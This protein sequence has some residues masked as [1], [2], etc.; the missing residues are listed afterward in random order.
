[1][2]PNPAELDWLL[3]AKVSVRCQECRTGSWD[4]SSADPTFDRPNPCK[5]Q[6]SKPKMRS[7]T[8]FTGGDP[9]R[10]DEI[11]LMQHG[12][13]SGQQHREY[14]TDQNFRIIPNGSTNRDSKINLW[15]QSFARVVQSDEGANEQ[16]RPSL[17][18]GLRRRRDVRRLGPVGASSPRGSTSQRVKLWAIS[19]AGDL[20]TQ[21]SEVTR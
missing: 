14:T 20:A 4:K 12:P 1:M 21:G 3:V 16:L 2:V 8:L 18:L 13:Q 17:T 11:M 5:W 6:P 10:T 7:R 9:G 15:I 19:T